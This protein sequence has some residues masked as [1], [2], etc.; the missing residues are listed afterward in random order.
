M[1]FCAPPTVVR[2]VYDRAGPPFSKDYSLLSTNSAMFFSLR[3]VEPQHSSYREMSVSSKLSILNECRREP[4]PWRQT[5]SSCPIR[6]LTNAA[7]ID[8]VSLRKNDPHSRRSFWPSIRPR[9]KERAVQN[10]PLAGR[11]ASVERWHRSVALVAR[12]LNTNNKIWRAIRNSS[13]LRQEGN[14]EVLQ[15]PRQSDLIKSLLNFFLFD[16]TL[17]MIKHDN[18]YVHL[19][20]L[21]VDTLPPAGPR[22]TLVKL[23]WAPTSEHCGLCDHRVSG[24]SG[25][26]HA[27]C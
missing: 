5:L 17:Y 27:S 24:R 10:D 3:S 26:G 1:Y 23:Q 14:G 7:I 13:Q 6:S 12:S 20:G 11:Q 22:P 15:V 2:A 8:S 4:S 25:K 21:L 9:T 16:N 18:K 19:N